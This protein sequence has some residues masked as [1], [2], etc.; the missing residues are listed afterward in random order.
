MSRSLSRAR[1]TRPVGA[2]KLLSQNFLANPGIAAALVRS[3]GVG[4]ED[5]V[6][7]IGPGDGMLTDRLL[8]T[9]GR[10]LA[11]EIDGH[12]AAR[13]RDRYA[14]DHRI[15]CCHRDFRS[16][17]APREP[18]AV[19]ANIPFASSTDIVR[20]CVAAPN[21]TSATL[22]T[23]REFARKH[24]GDYGRWTKLAVTHWPTTAFELGL[25]VDRRQFRPIPRVDAAVLRLRTRPVPLLPARAMP[26]YHRMVELGFSGVGGS[27]AASLSRAFPAR[28][29]RAACVRAGVR[30]DQPV[31]SVS[32][33]NWI[34]VHVN[35]CSDT[36]GV[37]GVTV[38]VRPRSG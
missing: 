32:P 18:F 33:G 20:W 14:G 34:D 2:R 26:G 37:P 3:S 1:T 11:Y 7:E 38:S 25:R 27:F 36:S 9:A 21:L 35:L 29:V 16:V 17:T 24:S 19:V 22:L 23:Q 5:L 28:R 8:A 31:G 13:L 10:V 4:A 6:V 12:Y 15:R 30:L